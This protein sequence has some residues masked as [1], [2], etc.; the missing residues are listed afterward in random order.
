MVLQ[1][2]DPVVEAR[3]LEGSKKTFAEVWEEWTNQHRSKWRSLRHVRI[4]LSHCKP[5]AEIP[6]NKI[7]KAMIIDTFTDLYKNHPDQALRALRMCKQV[8]DYAIAKDYRSGPNPAEWRGHLEHIFPERPKANNNHYPQLPFQDVPELM[9][10]LSLR[11]MKGT[12]PLALRFQILTAS[13]PGETLGMRFSEVDLENRIWTLPPERTKQNRQHRVPLSEACMRI[14]ALQAE[15][16][17]CDFVFT[18]RSNHVAL[19]LK[20]LRDLL[21]A[22]DL[23]K[24]VT[25]SGFRKSFR[26]WAARARI[27]GERI[28]RDL[29]E[30]C[31][32]HLIKG[33]VEEAYWT[34][35]AI[36]ERR[37]IMQEW[38]LYC[39]G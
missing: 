30:M 34:E 28:D 2:K 37:E 8:L 29:A 25:P 22:M 23:P 13:R 16:R 39:S 5:L 14:L 19:N 26:N 20:A 7:D 32:G 12:S 15:Y 6:V 9:R 17:T 36:D 33:K 10:R 3:K 18:G 38:A 4:L 35:D 24:H 1:G 11:E 21:R 27:N 31:L